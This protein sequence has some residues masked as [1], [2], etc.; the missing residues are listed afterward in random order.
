V[1]GV[2]AGTKSMLEGRPVPIREVLDSAMP[3]AWQQ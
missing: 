1:T 3:L 2:L